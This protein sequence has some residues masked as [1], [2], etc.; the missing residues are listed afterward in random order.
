[1]P[2]RRR[3]TRW[4]ALVLPAAGALLLAGSAL[5]TPTGTG[6]AVAAFFP[7]LA[8][9][10]AAPAPAP[11]GSA[12]AVA[13]RPP[14]PRR[15]NRDAAATTRAGERSRSSS[16]G[17]QD[18]APAACGKHFLSPF[19]G[20]LS[21][22]SAYRSGDGPVH[23]CPQWSTFGLVRGG[24]RN[25]WGVDIAS[26]TGTS[27]RAATDG[28]VSYAREAAGYG[29]HARLKFLAS[30]RGKSGS[31]GPSEEIEIIYAHLIDDGKTETTTRS[32]RAGEVIGRVG[33]TGN[34]RGM[35]SP[36]PESHLHVTVQKVKN[37]VKLDPGA[38]L[39]WNLHMP[40]EHPAEWVVCGR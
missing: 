6:R 16:R 23:F 20:G 11:V 28:V 39:G 24:H 37:K 9:S 34:A 22:R 33:C 4:F 38:F 21:F 5:G 13:P 25:H 19:E 1:M 14:R 8:G 32:V 35:C 31:C 27:V 15:Q 17:G 7:V 30:V 18:H 36:S 40:T 26:P 12:P 2:R 3:K 29:L 10:V